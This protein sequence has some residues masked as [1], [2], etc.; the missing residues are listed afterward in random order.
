MRLVD[1]RP[2]FTRGYSTRRRPPRFIMLHHTNTPHAARTRAVLAKRG[3]ATHIEVTGDGNVL[4]YLDPATKSAWHAGSGNNADSIGIDFTHMP[5]EPF[6][7]AQI[8]AGRWIVHQL[9][10][11]FAIPLTVA[12]DRCVIDPTDARCLAGVTTVPA[13]VAA[14][15]GVGRHRNVHATACPDDLPIEQLVASTSASGSGVVAPLVTA[16][17]IAAGLYFLAAA[18]RRRTT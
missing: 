8:A 7:P 16:G 13:L 2:A 3:R 1:M 5:G 10:A 11:Q 6:T 17:A 4:L 12:P 9:A 15:Y 18:R 14:G